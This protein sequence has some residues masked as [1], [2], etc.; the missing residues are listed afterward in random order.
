M[1]HALPS[2]VGGDSNLTA[3]FTNGVL[4]NA[5]SQNGKAC[6]GIYCDVFGYADVHF[7]QRRLEF[8]AKYS[9]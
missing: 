2:F 1:N 4:S 6:P 9:F 5:T 8:S 3:S 7:G